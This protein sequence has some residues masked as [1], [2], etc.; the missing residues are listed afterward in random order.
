[1]DSQR[2]DELSKV[3][4]S[5]PSRRGVVK[6]IGGGIIAGTL[7]LAGRGRADAG[8]AR[9]GVCHRT[10]N[11]NKPISLIQVS[12]GAAATLL[13]R[14]D[15]ALGSVTDCSSCGDACWTPDYATAYCDGGSCGFTC[16]DGYQ[17]NEAGD[18]CVSIN[19]C[20]E[21]YTEVN[22]ACFRAV[23]NMYDCPNYYGCVGYG[24]IQGT[25]S[26]VCGTSMSGTYCPNWSNDEC[27]TGTACYYYSQSCIAPCG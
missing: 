14:G 12:P 1:M 18:A 4:A 25:G 22:G 26:Y 17:L 16:D 9:V 27:P 24:S 19:P 13:S 3:L 23:S 21:G 7:A 2:F 8:P 10:G 15:T 6:G 5:R 11:V 20:S